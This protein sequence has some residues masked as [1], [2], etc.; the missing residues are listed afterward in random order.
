MG[1]PARRIDFMAPRETPEAGT[2]FVARHGLYD[3]AQTEA[4]ARMLEQVRERGLEVVRLS[5]ADQHGILRGKTIVADELPSML[6]NGWRM[7][8]TLLAKDTAHKTVYPVFTEGGGF[9]MDE[10][11]G[12]GDFVMVGDPATFRILPWAQATGWMLSDIYFPNG[13]P[14]PFSTRA[15]C[16]GVLDDLAVRGYDFVAGLEV[17]FHLFKLEDPMLAPEHAGQPATPPEVSLLAHGFQYLTEIRYDEL[18][19]VLAILRRDLLDLGLPLRTM[20]AEFG[21]SQCE[22]T[23]ATRTGLE[24]ADDM[25]LFRSA[26][27]QICR[28]NGYHATFMCRPGIANLFSSGWHLHQSLR[29]TDTGSNA[30]AS[31]DDGYLSP[32]ARG[33]LAGMLAHARAASVFTTPTI[34]GY[35]RFQAYSL[36]PDR[37]IWARDNRGVMIRALGGG[38]AAETRLENRV[39]EP[40]ANPYLY[41][42]SQILSGLDG[43]D[44]GLEPPEP[45]GTPYET[46]AEALPRSLMEALQAL[47]DSTMFRAALGDRFIDY[48]L[49]LKQAEVSRFLATVTDW[50][51]RE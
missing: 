5:F 23:F 32:L 27:K 44:R 12:G 47:D 25:I 43:I 4:A 21:P 50:E 18:D 9:G 38:E 34:N 3:E 48:I 41:M 29:A 16:R 51:H 49:T 2:G 36:A 7:T 19:P 30:F 8:T 40:A 20:E 14:V 6:R 13:V 46:E 1:L 24:A 10:M 15:I 22:V 11:T 31:D 37:A 45:V 17:E 28:R 33:Y 35:K 26:V 42:V 39:G